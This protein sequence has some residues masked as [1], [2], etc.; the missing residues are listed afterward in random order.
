MR[1][2]A[3]RNAKHPNVASHIQHRQYKAIEVVWSTTRTMSERV[4]RTQD[5]HT[6]SG[7]RGLSEAADFCVW[8]RGAWSCS[9]ALASC[10][11]WQGWPGA[12]AV[13][14]GAQ[15]GGFACCLLFC[16][17]ALL[18][19]LCGRL[20]IEVEGIRLMMGDVFPLLLR[21]GNTPLT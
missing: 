19:P 3:V 8:G 9:R 21:G 20:W 15:E 16:L 1:A 10:A 12:E 17:P 5:K 6:S 18:F 13:G 11:A 14:I 4:T 2:H 7:R